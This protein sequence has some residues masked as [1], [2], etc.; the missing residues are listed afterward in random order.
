M[1]RD[2]NFDATPW[3]SQTLEASNLDLADSDAVVG[4]PG[5]MRL[6]RNQA[7]NTPVPLPSARLTRR[8]WADT[9]RHLI[10]VYEYL[11]HVGE[12]EQWIEGCLDQEL[13]FGVVEMKE[14]LRNGVV[15]AK[16]VR[17]FQGE[18]VVRRIYA[19]YPVLLR[20]S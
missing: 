11:C 8:L 13:G 17:V 10:Q 4:I 14:G 5:R 3:R 19:S 12:A 1:R 6:S 16:L 20:S 2:G 18:G 9:Q 7:P 15:P